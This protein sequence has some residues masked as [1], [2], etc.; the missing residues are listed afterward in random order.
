MTLEYI[1]LVIICPIIGAVIG[2]LIL[3]AV[4]IGIELYK[5]GR[6]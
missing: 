6:D 1:F 2:G 3:L 5:D 4:G